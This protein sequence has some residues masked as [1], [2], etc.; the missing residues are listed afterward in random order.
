MKFQVLLST[1]AVV[2]AVCQ[3]SGY[4][5]STQF[6]SLSLPY[7]LPINRGVIP[8]STYSND[9]SVSSYPKANL[10]SLQNYSTNSQST[11]LKIDEIIR[12][13]QL[14]LSTPVKSIATLFSRLPSNL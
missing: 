3:Q 1:A 9:V 4:T 6:E 10:F 8:R 5:F 12:N 13:A 11:N 7:N 14:Q 2:G